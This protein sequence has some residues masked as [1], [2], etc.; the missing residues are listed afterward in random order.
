MQHR[1]RLAWLALTPEPERE[2]P[3]IVAALRTRTAPPPLPDLAAEKRRMEQLVL[4]GSARS[5]LRY[6]AEVAGLIRTAMA[7]GQP[8]ELAY[9]ALAAEVLLDHHRLLIGLPGN[10]YAATAADRRFLEGALPRLRARTRPSSE[11]A[12]E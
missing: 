4:H 12:A 10:G 6:L 9:A 5:W 8:D 3:A 7:R 11:R 1:A 2:L